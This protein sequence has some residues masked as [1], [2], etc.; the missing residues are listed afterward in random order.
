MTG[1]R[2]DAVTFDNGPRSCGGTSTKNAVIAARIAV[3]ATLFNTNATTMLTTIVMGITANDDDILLLPNN[4][5]L[6]SKY[7]FL[8]FLC[9]H[10]LT[11]NI[12][13]MDTR[14]P[15]TDLTAK[16]AKAK[17]EFENVQHQLKTYKNSGVNDFKNVN[18]II[19]NA[20]TQLTK[21]SHIVEQYVAFVQQTCKPPVDCV[22]VRSNLR[23][24][25]DSFFRLKSAIN[26][27]GGGRK[28]IV[29]YEQDTEN[30]LSTYGETMTKLQQCE[31]QVVNLK[32]IN[33]HTWTDII[34]FITKYVTTSKNHN[35]MKLFV[36][37]FAAKVP[38]SK[39]YVKLH[40]SL[41]HLKAVSLKNSDSV[42]YQDAMKQEQ[43]L[44]VQ[45]SNESSQE[46]VNKD[47]D[48]VIAKQKTLFTQM[49][50]ST[51]DRMI[52][53]LKKKVVFLE[54]QLRI[55]RE[56]IF[57][58]DK[59]I[60]EADHQHNKDFQQN[61]S[62][63]LHDLTAEIEHIAASGSN[64]INDG[65]LTILIKYSALSDDNNGSVLKQLNELQ[66]KIDD[67]NQKAYQKSDRSSAVLSPPKIES[68][69]QSK[70]DP[71][72]LTIQSNYTKQCL[73]KISG[74]LLM[75]EGELSRRS[76]EIITNDKLKGLESQSHFYQLQMES[77]QQQI[78]INNNSDV[79]VHNILSN[80]LA[81]LKD[82]LALND[83]SIIQLKSN[84]ANDSKSNEL[85]RD[86]LVQML[87]SPSYVNDLIKET[88]QAIFKGHEKALTDQFNELD[89]QYKQQLKQQNDIKTGS[90]S[91]PTEEFFDPLNESLNAIKDENHAKTVTLY[92]K[93][94]HSYLNYR[95][96]QY[97]RYIQRLQDNLRHAMQINDLDMIRSLTDELNE[98]V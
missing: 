20:T 56:K 85:V 3:D 31:G 15:V 80:D 44:V 61:Q 95:E 1:P 46:V 88:V 17:T 66:K 83:E 51:N 69:V 42:G 25:E 89:T 23:N 55:H 8:L 91:A 27:D 2:I 38:T 19:N 9:C 53:M 30:M 4:I 98:N 63:L 22:T 71:S 62:K 65:L 96:Q 37:S 10:C 93:S 35:D 48:D 43:N 94:Y 86:K 82:S 73:T 32:D 52:D 75:I 33:L 92:P 26:H 87:E 57:T 64:G 70:V 13:L 21:W 49:L 90:K 5:Y 79:N 59:Q 29:D 50:L 12:H 67:I 24:C 41:M 7:C 68:I 74:I 14:L 6:W 84:I 39:D 58:V 28:T 97:Y 40:D 45:S 72:L 11:Y 60:S 18:T 77:L 34:D 36:E 78:D 54:K 16:L 76:D 47:Y 81:V